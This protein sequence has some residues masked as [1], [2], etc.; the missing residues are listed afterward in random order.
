MLDVRCFSFRFRGSERECVQGIL[1]PTL[2]SL[3]PCEERERQLRS[4]CGK[5]ASQRSPR[6]D[7]RFTDGV[8]DLFACHIAVIL[9]EVARFQVE[10]LAG[11]KLVIAAGSQ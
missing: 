11:L 9:N 6:L 8:R 10:E 2:S 4:A 5:S 1:T 3:V 7:Y